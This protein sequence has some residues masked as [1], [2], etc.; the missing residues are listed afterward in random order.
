MKRGV[1]F[2]MVCLAL[3]AASCSSGPKG[4]QSYSIQADASSAPGKNFQFSAFYPS[5]IKA[6][7]GDTIT[8]VNGGGVAPHSVS[9]GVKPDHSNA[10]PV[11]TPAGENPAVF[12]ACVMPQDPTAKLTACPKQYAKPAPYTGS[13]YW[14]GFMLP[15]GTP[16][17][18]GPT[19][20]TLQLAS[21]IAPGTYHFQCLLHAPMQATLEV[22]A[23]D[24]DRKT[25]ADLTAEVKSA[26][27]SA[28]AQADKIA[29]PTLAPN[30]VA[31]GF[32]SANVAVNRFYPADLSV[33]AGTKVTWKDFSDFEPHT[34][35]FGS[36]QVQGSPSAFFAPSGVAPGGTFSGGKANSGIFGGDIPGPK[37]Y[38]LTFA[39]KGKYT[40]VCEL[41]P[42]MK[43]T[44][45]VT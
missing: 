3:I 30:N 27:S 1:G 11:V 38:S 37:E 26:V 44:I 31:A 16:S 18:V 29:N 43:A 35:T 14:N 32:S 24:S 42:G 15:A 36:P 2:V 20:V 6:R 7:P 9:F 41:H 45:T 13:G 4:A 28:Q 10:P 22:V 25:P 23:K 19:K 34:V 5:V 40:Y 12:M 17:Q 8:I 21:S 33:K 39:T